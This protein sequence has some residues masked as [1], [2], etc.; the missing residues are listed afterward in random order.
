MRNTIIKPFCILSFAQTWI[1]GF[2]WLLSHL[3]FIYNAI[4][5]KIKTWAV[6]LKHHSGAVG[7]I[8]ALQ[9]LGC[10]FDPVWVVFYI[11]S[12][13]STLHS[14]CLLTALSCFC[15]TYL[16]WHTVFAQHFPLLP[17]YKENLWTGEGH[18]QMEFFDLLTSLNIAPWSAIIFFFIAGVS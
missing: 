6:M 3:E 7:R 17:D 13:W 5:C 2:S 4:C 11:W 18:K 16:D 10:R 8:V 1:L 12:A 15:S 9:P 14:M